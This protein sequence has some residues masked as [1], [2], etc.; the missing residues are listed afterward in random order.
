[1]R[2]PNVPN[3]SRSQGVEVRM[4]ERASEVISYQD[5]LKKMARGVLML[6]APGL[7]GRHLYVAALNEAVAGEPL[8]MTR[9]KL[10]F[11]CHVAMRTYLMVRNLS[12]R[13]DR[14][15][16][17]VISETCEGA[18]GEIVRLTMAGIKSGRV[19]PHWTD[20]KPEK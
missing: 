16:T 17:Q 15:A 19:T 9:V 20:D 7:R 10:R 18:S 8:A 6:S 12:D 13:L 14:M 1:M 11:D 5:V 4:R 2:R 3:K